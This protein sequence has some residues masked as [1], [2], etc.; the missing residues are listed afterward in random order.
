MEWRTSM[1][2]DLPTPGLKRRRRKT[3]RDKGYWVAR[4]D[5]VKAGY[6]PETVP[7][8]Y[9]LDDRAQAG[10]ISAACMRLQAEMLEWS[11]GHRS[12]LARFDGTIA[13]LSRRFQTDAASPFNRTWKWKVREK[14]VYTLRTIEKA[15]G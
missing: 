14:E 10:L 3:G 2:S 8:S 1:H 9:D 6:R 15:F 5:L 4:A 12:D 13:G 11:A 7:L